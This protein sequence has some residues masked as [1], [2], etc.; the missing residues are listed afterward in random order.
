MKKKLFSLLLSLALLGSLTITLAMASNISPTDEDMELNAIDTYSEI[1]SHFPT[2][3]DGLLIYPD[4]FGDAYY[5]DGYLH[6]NVK[7]LSPEK[8]ALYSS[9]CS[10]SSALIFHDVDYSY[11]EL[12]NLADQILELNVNNFTTIGVNVYDNLV[13]VGI[14]EFSLEGSSRSSSSTLS[15]IRNEIINELNIPSSYSLDDQ[16]IPISVM[17]QK[18]LSSQSTLRGGDGIYASNGSYGTMAICGTWDGKPAILT[19]GHVVDAI[20]TCYYGSSS[21]SKIGSSLYMQYESGEKYDWGVYS[22][23]NHTLTARVLTN[24]GYESITSTITESKELVGSSVR[25]YGE[26]S[27]YSTGTITKKNVSVSDDGF[28]TKGMTLCDCHSESGDSGAPVY[29]FN[30]LKGILSAGNG[31]EMA[32]SPIYGVSSRFKVQLVN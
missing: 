16:S 22:A 2:G 15:S 11:N 14:D 19:A 7:N 3:P 12:T 30:C 25:K 29:A 13:E 9:Y 5:Q 24:Y 20:S 26:T 17:A 23:N 28:V 21:G 10:D 18:P 6:V 31:T 32:Y 1:L 4:D 8:E 27:H